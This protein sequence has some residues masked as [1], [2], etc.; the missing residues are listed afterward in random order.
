MARRRMN[1]MASVSRSSGLEK[2]GDDVFAN[3]RRHPGESENHKKQRLDAQ[4]NV[5]ILF[6]KFF[7][8]SLLNP[9]KLQRLVGKLR[10][11][12]ASSARKDTFALEGEFLSA[13]ETSLYLSV[14]F[15]S[16]K[17]TIS[18]IPHL[19][20]PSSEPPAQF[21]EALPSVHSLL[22]SLLHHLVAS[23][24]SQGTY[25]QH[26]A[27][28]PTTALPPG[29]R[30]SLW[31]KSVTKNLR[32]RNYVKFSVLSQKAT[33][34]KLLEPPISTNPKGSGSD[35]LASN[36]VFFLVDAL[37]RKASET[38]WNIL[39][40]AYRELDQCS[41]GTETWLARSL[42]MDSVHG[43]EWTLE[44]GYWLET[45]ASLGHV[46][47]KEDTAGKWIVCKSVKQ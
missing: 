43:D 40:S 11:G 4:E 38:A 3:H 42:F 45:K 16:P 26:L 25:H 33:V 32:M 15:E 31:L 29:S 9:A 18:I 8:I 36:A 1:L 35:I 46:R 44:A 19:F 34:A 47:R 10:E 28:I 37:R 21:T 14:I 22:C 30:L 20:P 13:Y 5:L 6:R 39:R 12:V 23:Y 24:P 17:Q 27:S 2:D 41:T 7:N